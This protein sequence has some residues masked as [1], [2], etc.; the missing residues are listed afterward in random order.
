MKNEQSNPTIDGIRAAVEAAAGRTLAAIT[1]ERRAVC[2]IRA[3]RAI[4][5]DEQFPRGLFISAEDKAG[6]VVWSSIGTPFKT[7]AVAK[8]IAGVVSDAQAQ[9]RAAAAEREA[10]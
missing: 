3:M 1:P 5:T 10:A 7:P 8:F 6:F 9:L 2:L 4:Q